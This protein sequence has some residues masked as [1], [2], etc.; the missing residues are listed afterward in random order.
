[1][2]RIALHYVCVCVWMASGLMRLKVSSTVVFAQIYR[3]NETKKKQEFEKL[4]A[5]VRSSLSAATRITLTIA[6]V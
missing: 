1:M 3:T 5:N 6:F 2:Y 4:L